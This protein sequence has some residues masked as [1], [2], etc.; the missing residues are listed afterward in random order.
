MAKLE[1]QDVPHSR[2]DELELKGKIKKWLAAHHLKGAQVLAEFF[3]GPFDQ[4]IGC[5]VEVRSGQHS[6]R[7]FEYGKG[8]HHTLLFCLRGLAE[9]SALER[10]ALMER[11]A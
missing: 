6:W 1:F 5:Y 8:M 4:R 7:N 10:D 11:S 2:A 3:R 9:N